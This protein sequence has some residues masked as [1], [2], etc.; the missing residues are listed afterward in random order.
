LLI[1]RLLGP[2]EVLQDGARVEPTS[3]KQRALLIDLVIRRG[4]VVSRDR[5]IDDLW[6]EDPPAT[7]A[8]VLQNYVSHLRRALGS[9]VVRTVGAGYAIATE[10]V[11]VDVAELDAHLA[12]ARTAREA[13]DPEAV[14]Q[15]T[16]DAVALWRGEPLTDVALERFAQA[17]ITRL[18]EVRPET[19]ELQVEA[20]VAAG[21][22]HAA[23]A[24]LEAAI[25]D[26]PL[27]ERLWWLLMLALH[28]SG[29]QA[30][31][32][33]AFQRARAVLGDELGLEPGVELRDLERAILDQRP[34]LDDLL[35][36]SPKRRPTLRRA[37]SRPTLVGRAD[38]WSVIIRHL[39]DAEQDAAGLLL[40][41][42]EPGIGKTRLLEEAQ[43][44][45]EAGGG[46]VIAGRAFEAERGRPYGP[47]VDA[48]RGVPLP[49][50]DDALRADLA[51]LLPEIAAARVE[52]NDINRLHDG[53]T[54]LIRSLAS[55]AP[56][57]V[58]LDD[59]HWLDEQSASLLSFAI[60]HL[61]D[62]DVS[63]VATARPTELD[64]SETCARVMQG[65]RRDDALA[66]LRIGPL[67][68]ATIGELTEPIA[69]GADAQRIAEATNGNPLFA[70]EMARALARGDDP[71]SS[72][73]DALIG[74]RLA[75][76]DERAN[77]LIPWLAAFGRGIAPAILGGL[78]E[79]DPAELFEPLGD[80]ERQGL[81]RADDDG[82]Y[83]FTHDL[84]R[85]AAYKRLST[86]R[87][88][89]LHSRIGVVLASLPDSDDSLA[90]DAARHADAGGDSAVCAA[91]CIRAARRCLRLLAYADAEDLVVLGRSHARRLAEDEQVSMELSLI[92]VL[93]HPGVRLRD[94]G[95]LT[96]D[97]T[98]LC[99]DAQRLG[100][101]AELSGGLSLLA[102]AYHWGWGDIPR[103]R[104]LLQRAAEVIETA[105]EPNIDP[106]LEG[107]RC[108]AYLEIDMDR[109]YRLF[110]DLG[111]LHDLAASSLQYQWGLGL[112]RSWAGELD[113]ARAALTSAI[114]I[115]TARG[116]HWATFECSAR[117]ALLELEAGKCETA[118]P[119]CTQL[120]PLAAKLGDGSERSYAAALG[121]LQAFACGD[122]A[123]E[124]AL[125]EALAA[126]E[127]IGAQFLVPDLLGIAAEIHLRAGELD[128][129]GACANRARRVADEVNR[130]LE[131][132][133]AHA[134]L[135]CVAAA[136]GDRDAAAAHVRASASETGRVSGHVEGLRRE[137]ERLIEARPGEQ[138]DATWL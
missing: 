10:L 123:G 39:D 83:D 60:R 103:A 35:V 87:R 46:T 20:E 3:P 99:A 100:L 62:A 84:V 6:G 80:L 12:R 105:S 47:W 108:L 58:L 5:L 23:V 120:A 22:H 54:R 70:L 98:D 21:R 33:R 90:A 94:P 79:R 109:T 44:M 11:R 75:R 24:H 9:D 64:D 7:A 116:D 126:L 133:R 106:L 73:V 137:A 122:P 117:L 1:I 38:E 41:V 50:L 4:E 112:V 121:A 13:G 63:F 85:S 55:D 15:A 66:E 128:A 138:G 88:A 36:W 31:A 29:R 65:L 97:L 56:A 71:L 42:G 25:A 57:A 34:D 43:A 19:L 124:T 113:G 74:D 27:H 81:L 78:V 114:D 101:Q 102:R 8:G 125:D 127:R 119:L 72:R 40:L 136:R 26:H 111:A 67:P 30:E 89:M 77:T 82:T 107:A 52:L 110:D 132:S 115:A 96:R 135:A 61:A 53:V 76:L 95:E 131:A 134:L 69:P 130:P 104:V 32:L 18:R 92:H 2:L 129:A 86:P 28:R 68:P 45:I 51:P 48:L 16:S 37:R 14:R 17:E 93:L 91:A 59:V 118:G 49:R